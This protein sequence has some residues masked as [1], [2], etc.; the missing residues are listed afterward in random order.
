MI[1]YSKYTKNGNT[2]SDFML[3]KTLGKE[4]FGKVKLGT[5]II[6][7]EHVFNIP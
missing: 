5:H 2:R 1:K 7:G 3:G 4:T 6:T